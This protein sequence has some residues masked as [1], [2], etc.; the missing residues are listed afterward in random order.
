MSLS[1]PQEAAGPKG[2]PPHPVE[3]GAGEGRAL[4]ELIGSLI[5]IHA[6]MAV[7]RVSGS[8]WVLR[9]G[10]GEVMVGVLMSLF[11]LAPLGLSMWAGRL[12]DRHGLHRPLNW[13]VGMALAGALSSALWQSLASI[14]LAALLTGGALSMAAVAIQREVSLRAGQGD[15]LKRAFSWMA[16]GPALSNS[17]S[18]VLAGVLIDHGGFGQAFAAAA[19]MPVVAWALV[20]RLPRQP[21]Q[22]RVDAP[23]SQPAWQLLRIPAFRHLLILNVLLSASWD[24][25]SFVVPVLGQ[26]RGMSASAIGLV[27]GSFAVA[28]TLV[29][30]AIVRWAQHLEERAALRAAMVISAV[31]LAAYVWLPGTTGLMFGSALL[32]LALGSVQPMILSTLHQV[33]P[34][35]RHGQALGLRMLASNGGTLALPLLFGVMAGATQTSAPLWLMACLL[36]LAQPLTAA[37]HSAQEVKPDQPSTG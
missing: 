19:C 15:A 36:V 1:G 5:A 2:S 24:V 37:L 6:C 22:A 27:L 25:H 18:P 30:L 12:S 7:T 17:L 16:L 14:A 33:T 10:H 11:A 23:R 21:P 20:A 4:A 13:G 8:L 28:A 35:D 34:P 29:R 31:V 26:A 3:P 9:H 32:G